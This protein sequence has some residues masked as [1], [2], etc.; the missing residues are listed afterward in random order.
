MA[1]NQRN[2]NE[3]KL[4]KST[5]LYVWPV[6]IAGV[7][8]A[9][10]LVKQGMEGLRIYPVEAEDPFR[11]IAGYLPIALAAAIVVG[12]LVV[13]IK[14]SNRRVGITPQFVLYKK[15]GGKMQK[16]QWNR[17]SISVPY[18]QHPGIFSRASITDGKNYIS[19][20]KYFFK[21]FDEICQV[22]KETREAVQRG[23]F[24]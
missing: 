20:E 3:G 5:L 21:E 23:D 17:L 1:D 22:L 2:A 14:N 4:Y 18:V 10:S 13:I 16:L 9:V 15:G 6:L 12:M 11:F 19:I 8:A 24:D 7:V